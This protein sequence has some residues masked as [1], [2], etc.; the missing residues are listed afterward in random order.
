MNQVRISRSVGNRILLS[1]RTGWGL[2]IFAGFGYIP[3]G[4]FLVILAW[5]STPGPYEIGKLYPFGSELNA[6]QVT[7]GFAFLAFGLLF[8]AV[9]LNAVKFKSR[10]LWTAA[11]VSFVLMWFPHAIIGISFFFYDPTLI[12]L[13]MWIIV[14]PFILLWMFT[15][16]LGFWLSWRNLRSISNATSQNESNQTRPST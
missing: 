2:L 14:L 5:Q 1:F 15:A 11:L 12:S 7:N 4:I 13:E 10:L 3:G 9:L 8:C 6:W 16:G